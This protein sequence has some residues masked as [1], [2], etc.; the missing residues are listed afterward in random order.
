MMSWATAMIP[1]T[2]FYHDPDP[3]GYAAFLEWRRNAL[4]ELIEQIYLLFEEPADPSEMVLSLPPVLRPELKFARDC[5]RLTFAQLFAYA[6]LELSGQRVIVANVDICGINQVWFCEIASGRMPRYFYPPT[7]RRWLCGESPCYRRSLW[8]QKRF[9]AID[10]AED[11][12]FVCAAPVGQMVDLDAH[13]V[14][15]AIAHGDN[16][17]RPQPLIDPNWVR[18]HQIAAPNILGDDRSFYEAIARRAL[19][20]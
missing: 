16:T 20:A 17:S 3:T 10:I 2:G 8:Q 13:G 15:I 6:N 19:V 18:S 4:N 7:Q 12:R 11:T 9:E 1:L 5:G 14:M